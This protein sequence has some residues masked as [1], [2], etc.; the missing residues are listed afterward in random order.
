MG[1]AMLRRP[2]GSEVTSAVKSSKLA[3]VASSTLAMLSVVGQRGRPLPVMRLDLLKE[4]G[5]RP[6]RLAR[7][8]GENPKRRATGFFGA[9]TRQWVSLFMGEPRREIGIYTYR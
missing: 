5:S 9:K 7:P 6:A 8:E 2:G 1:C 4:V 3:P